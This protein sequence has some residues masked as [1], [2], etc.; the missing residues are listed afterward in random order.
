MLGTLVLVMTRAFLSKEKS[1]LGYRVILAEP[2]IS[3]DF[4]DADK[5][6]WEIHIIMSVIKGSLY[7][8]TQN[9]C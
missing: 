1:V 2:G 3:K 9:V 5:F 7:K 6:L 4:M 8:V